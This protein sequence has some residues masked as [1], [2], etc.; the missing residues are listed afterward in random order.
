M[1]GTYVWSA[2]VSTIGTHT[3]LSISSRDHPTLGHIRSSERNICLVCESL[4]KVDTHTVPS[5]W[6]IK[7]HPTL[8]LPRGTCIWSA[9][10]LTFG[11]H[12]VPHVWSRDHP[13]LG[14][15]K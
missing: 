6:S 7:D 8:G 1:R 4:H 13:T 14:L 5:I 11:Q 10:V 3:E 9:K 12:T 2:K 15:V